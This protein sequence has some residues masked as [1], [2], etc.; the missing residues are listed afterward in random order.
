MVIKIVIGVIFIVLI[1]ILIWL[2]INRSV[3]KKV[4][5]CTWAH[6]AVIYGKEVDDDDD[7]DEEDDTE[8]LSAAGMLLKYFNEHP[9][10]A[11]AIKEENR[12]KA[13]KEAEEDLK[14]DFPIKKS[15]VKQIANRNGALKTDFCRN[16]E[17]E[18]I[19]YLSF[20]DY[21]VDLIEKDNR[22]YWLYQV[23]SGDISW[24]N[25]SKD[26]TEFCDGWFGDDD[27]KYLRCLIDAQTGDYIYFPNVE[28]YQERTIKYKENENANEA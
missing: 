5:N 16:S 9:E 1:A 10:M 7:D 19:S 14:Y 15:F 26:G 3:I 11:E 25:S 20:D 17:R 27:L 23:L 8:N 13:A 28:N 4:I 12:K 21:S 18:G 6:F 22:K 2:Y 24:V